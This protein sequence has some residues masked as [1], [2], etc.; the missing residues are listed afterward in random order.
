MLHNIAILITVLFLAKT[1]AQPN[2]YFSEQNSQTIR[3]S[4]NNIKYVNPRKAIQFIFEVLEKYPQ[5]RPN[6]V[7]GAAYSSLGQI[8][9]VK[10]LDHQ[11]LDYLNQA[12]DE[13]EDLQGQR[14]TPWLEI[15]IGNIYFGIGMYSESKI[16]YRQAFDYFQEELSN[17]V[18]Y[19]YQVENFLD[20]LAVSSNNIALVEIKL[21]NYE[22]A[23]LEYSKGLNYRRNDSKFESMAHSYISLSELNLKWGR[24]DRVLLYCDSTQMVLK[25]ENKKISKNA[26]TINL[27]SGMIQKHLGERMAKL[28]Q[29]SDA[30]KYFQS[31]EIYFK[32]L[33]VDLTE[34]IATR[35]RIQ[36]QFGNQASALLTIDKGLTIANEQGLY[37]KK[38]EL[39]NLKI[40]L[41]SSMGYY[42]ESGKVAIILLELNKEKISIQN[43]DLFLN[44]TLKNNLRKNE[45]ELAKAA[46]FRKQL[47]LLSICIVMV[48][49]IVI[50]IFRNKNAL[51]KHKAVILS[52]DKKITDI[53]LKSA[54]HEL[55]YVTKSI[56]EKN[57]MIES[58]KKDV[59]YTA[60][61]IVHESDLNH[62]IKP[63][64]EK[65]NKTTEVSRGWGDFLNHFNRIYPAFI[66]EIT[67]INNSM[68]IKDLRLCIYLRSGHTTKEIANLTGL[69]IRSIESRRYRLRKKLALDPK[70][71]LA[72]FIMQIS[73]KKP[74]INS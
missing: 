4:I 50:L 63:L 18:H 64:L 26:E 3:D 67:S 33:P 39:L 12:E 1:T 23:E 53:N 66:K 22:L 10:G 27:Y 51:S 61:L 35:A 5:D 44:I 58:I 57:E 15:D 74:L 47:I 20:G 56:I 62:A 73:N 41:L 45:R 8:Y 25:K 19:P 32:S 71:D 30:H 31:A 59:E 43:K 40:K 52:K 34:L 55:Q 9:H 42:K 37:E 70:T 29:E 16:H 68:T 69:S 28:N 24:L 48:L 65:L 54:E 13:Y 49:G 36:S 72:N 2:V 38:N 7:F 60:K 14:R 46:T 17:G 6:K 11:A 21:G